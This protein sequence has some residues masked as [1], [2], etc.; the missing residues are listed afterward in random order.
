MANIRTAE[1]IIQ[2]L[3]DHG[4]P[5]RVIASKLAI[6]QSAVS[7]LLNGKRM[8]KLSEAI[9]ILDLLPREPAPREVPVIGMAGAGNW[10][11]AIEHA[12]SHLTVPGQ[13]GEAGAFAVEVS[14][15]SMNLLLPAGSLALIDPNDRSLFNSRVY[16]LRNGDGEATIKRYRTDPSRFEPV[17]DDPSFK[18]FEVGSWSFEVIGRVVSGHTRF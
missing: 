6:S 10:I 11:E 2:A 5:Q 4:V 17:S 9:A 14:G 8:M 18:P 16:L 12:S 3:R 1:Q 13:M 7:D 15:E